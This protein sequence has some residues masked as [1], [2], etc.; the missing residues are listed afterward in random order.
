M[1]FFNLDANER[2]L[3][4]MPTNGWTGDVFH[5]RVFMS[6]FHVSNDSIRM[7]FS[8][9]V[10]RNYLVPFTSRG[11]VLTLSDNFEALPPLVGN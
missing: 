4:K 8:E 3:L 10:L 5:V 9:A 7:D 6:L 2:Q 1:P 11:G